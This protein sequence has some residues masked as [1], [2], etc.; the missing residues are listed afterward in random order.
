MITQLTHA[1]PILYR[2]VVI[3]FEYKS[4]EEET[5]YN[6]FTL[7]ACIQVGVRPTVTLIRWH[8]PR[9]RKRLQMLAR[10]LKVSQGG[11]SSSCGCVG[12]REHTHA[13]SHIHAHACTTVTQT[14]HS[15]LNI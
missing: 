7:H 10:N 3:Y 13:H 2:K 9:P 14:I 15:V 11:K 8:K 6:E 1:N 4:N 12:I 5:D